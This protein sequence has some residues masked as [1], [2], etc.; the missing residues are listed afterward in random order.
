VTANPSTVGKVSQVQL[1]ATLGVT[2]SAYYGN[3]DIL[4]LLIP[5]P[6][7]FI[8]SNDTNQLWRQQRY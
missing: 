4:W 2:S 5:E 1:T 7:V 3:N 6:G 8:I